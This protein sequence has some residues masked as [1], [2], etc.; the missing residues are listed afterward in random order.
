MTI[1]YWIVA[2]LLA[3]AFLFASI[4]KLVTPKADL[5]TKGMLWVEAFSVASIR[6]IATAEALG[7]IGFIVPPLTGIAPILAPIAAVGL[8]ATMIGATVVHARRRETLVPTIVLTAL[9]I[10]AAVLGFAVFG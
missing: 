10:V 1:A 3:A 4:T 9:S 6:G 5:S 7:A 2:G 8:A